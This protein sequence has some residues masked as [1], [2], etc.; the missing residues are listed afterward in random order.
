MLYFLDF[1][2]VSIVNKYGNF[3]GD[4]G[5]NIFD[6]VGIYI[7][8]GDFVIFSS[9]LYVVSDIEYISNVIEK[10]LG[11]CFMVFL[12][13]IDWCKKYLLKISLID[14]FFGKLVIEDFIG[15]MCC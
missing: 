8:R 12:D 5:N 14:Y 15:L 13:D 4:I 9:K 3:M 7:C 2:R 1:L 10:F 11:R 6:Y